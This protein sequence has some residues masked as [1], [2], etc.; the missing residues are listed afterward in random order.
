MAHNFASCLQP[1]A[2]WH[3]EVEYHDVG[4]EF[5]CLSNGF[6]PVTGFRANVPFGMR[7]DKAVKQPADCGIIIG[8]Q[9][10]D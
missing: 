3:G 5:G 9:Y 8:D 2:E 1:I 7:F 4:S 6:L 10:A